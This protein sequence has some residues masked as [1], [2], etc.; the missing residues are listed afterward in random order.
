MTK[1][2][3]KIQQ[4][5]Q[6]LAKEQE[7]LSKKSGDENTKE[8]QDALNKKFEDLQKQMDE[9]D[10]ENNQLK[11]P[12]DLERSKEDE[13]DIKE[14]QQGA[15]E[16]LN[17]SEE[18]PQEQL[19]SEAQKSAKQ[20]QKKAA[21][22]MQRMSK[23]MQTAMQ[24]SGQQSIQEDAE[25]LR[26]ILDNLVLFSFD[27]ESLM[28]DFEEIDN[29]NAGY[30]AKLKRQKELRKMFEHV[31]DSLFA[32]SLRQ[33]KISEKINGEITEI[34]YN[35]DKSLE[36]LAENNVYRGVAAQQYA[37]TSTNKLA[38]FLSGALDNMNQSMGQGNGQGNQGMGQ[39]GQNQGQGKG[40][41]LPDII[42]SQEQ[43]NK[44]MQKGMQQE[45]Q[46]KDGKDG[47]EGGK[48]KGDKGKGNKD[49]QD[50]ENGQDGGG[51]SGSGDENESG[52]LY[53]IYKQQQALRNQLEKQLKD[54][55]GE[56][57]NNL[58]AR[59]IL[60]Q[61]EDVETELLERGF[62]NE[63]MKRMIELKYKLQKLDKAA[64]EQEKETRRES[65]TNR[66]DF[67]NTT[68]EKMPDVRQYF[69]QIEILNRQ[70][71]PLRNNYK[72]KVQE[73]FKKK[74]D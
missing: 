33:P 17:K 3:E 22:K 72:K 6:E 13:E 11:K 34:Y 66:K 70:V 38:D 16:D 62:N 59:E 55:F 50:G 35:I 7:E 14:E 57:I 24:M 29:S 25:M 28:K 45:G 39:S 52:K 47:K 1:K 27:E 58:E 71:L 69:N 41:Q 9:L 2:A 23:A 68:N 37:L 51:G 44:Q 42:Q 32:L 18:S 56:K 65:N 64:F 61:M 19:K 48:E 20:K 49:G 53:D 12:L 46:G 21:Q 30:A 40:F 26:Q 31:D 4:E 73:Y 36:Q 54:K 5:L 74:D 60:K 67:I 10:K 15:S 8:K 43:L 63:T